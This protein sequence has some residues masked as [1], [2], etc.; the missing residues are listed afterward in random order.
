M[1]TPTTTVIASMKSTNPFNPT[2][3]L[4]H[5]SPIDRRLRGAP[6]ARYGLRVAPDRDE[7]GRQRDDAANKRDFK[8][9]IRDGLIDEESLSEQERDSMHRA[10]V[11]REAA[12]DDRRGGA[13]DRAAARDAREASERSGE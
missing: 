5:P 6:A 4:R 2:H 3:G 8:A 13:A 12:A 9:A 10:R 7:R 11:D 1:D